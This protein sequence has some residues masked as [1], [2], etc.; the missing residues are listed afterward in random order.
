MRTATGR[1]PFSRR[2][3]DWTSVPLRAASAATTRRRPRRPSR[4]PPSRAGASGWAR[5]SH[6]RPR[7]SAR[8]GRRRGPR[9][10]YRRAPRRR[11]RWLHRAS[12]DGAGGDAGR[13]G[14]CAHGRLLPS[15]S[16]HQVDAA[17]VCPPGLVLPGGVH[18]ATRGGPHLRLLHSMSVEVLFHG[19][20][21]GLAEGQVVVG[22]SAGIGVSDQAQA[23][24][25]ERSDAEAFRHRVE[26][27]D[28]GRP[29]SGTSRTRST[30]PRPD[31]ARLADLVGD[32][33]PGR[34]QGIA[35]SAASQASHD[36]ACRGTRIARVGR[37]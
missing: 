2:P 27:A 15:A 3:R 32:T 16:K 37:A 9:D 28:V 30:R 23:P 6:R 18:R 29:E 7:Q 36:A 21:A 10:A 5:Q 12:D 31:A 8:R 14:D 13:P 25:R 11:R 20:R 22:L 17:V 24:T 1:A 19:V 34:T 35:E 26:G 33:A 4:R